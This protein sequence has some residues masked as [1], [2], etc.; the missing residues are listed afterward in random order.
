[1]DFACVC[2]FVCVCVRLYVC[3]CVC[4]RVCVCVCV[5]ICEVIESNDSRVADANV[6]VC[7]WERERESVCVYV[8]VFVCVCMRVCV[9]VCICV[10][11]CLC[12]VIRVCVCLCVQMH[13]D[14]RICLL[15]ALITW[16]M[17]M[18]HDSFMCAM[19]HACV[20]WHKDKR[21]C[22]LGTPITRLMQMCAM[23]HS[24]VTWL[25]GKRICLL[26][27]LYETVANKLPAKSALRLD[28]YGP[29]LEHL[30]NGRCVS[31]DICVTWLIH[32]RNMTQYMWLYVTCLDQ[33]APPL[34]RYPYKARLAWQS[35]SN[36]YV[37]TLHIHN[38]ATHICKRALYIR[39]RALYICKP[40]ISTKEP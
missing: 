30:Y 4:V 15:D 28:A 19:T 1:M 22:L 13:I 6:C 25:T 11:V 31:Y 8:C 40:Y 37:W 29:V 38:R 20:T 23:T 16:L 17:H 18:R 35:P 39:R 24:C 9:C 5:W 12:V 2:V 27:A 34:Y 10:S 36:P 32:V 26:D 14:K 3:V 7:V 21:I 33:Y